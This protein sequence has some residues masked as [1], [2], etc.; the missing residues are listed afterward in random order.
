M[1]EKKKTSLQDMNVDL[2]PE[3]KTEEEE[4]K[5]AELEDKMLKERKNIGKKMMKGM[6]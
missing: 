2:N 1:A 4:Q 5:D 6:E 3:W